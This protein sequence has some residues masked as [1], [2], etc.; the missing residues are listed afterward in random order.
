M[1][2]NLMEG[3]V[4]NLILFESF[5]ILHS[6]C[7]LP[8]IINGRCGLHVVHGTF[9]SGTKD[10]SWE[11]KE[12]L[13]NNFNILHGSPAQRDD[14][15]SRSGIKKFPLQHDCKCRVENAPVAEGLLAKYNENHKILESINQR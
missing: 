2:Q 4:T 10:T 12:T 15:T 14:F 6:Q 5:K 8:K 9:K 13:K 11:L 1:A 7:E 3:P